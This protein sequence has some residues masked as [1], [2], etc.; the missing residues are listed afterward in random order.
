MFGS[1]TFRVGSNLKFFWVDTQTYPIGAFNLDIYCYETGKL[2]RTLASLDTNSSTSPQEWDVDSTFLTSTSDCPMNQYQ[3]AFDWHYSDPVTL[4]PTV[5]TAKCK[6]LLLIPPTPNPSQPSPSDPLA[7][8]DPTSGD[9]YISDRTKNIII[10]V[11]CAVGVLI[12]AG[13]VGFYFIRYKN[14]RAEEELANQKLR[15]PLHVEGPDNTT[16]GDTG[17]GIQYSAMTG[18]TTSVP[19]EKMELEQIGPYSP[20]T[21]S[22]SGSHLPRTEPAPSLSRHSVQQ[23]RPSGSFTIERPPSLLTS[24]FTPPEDDRERVLRMKREEEERQVFEQQLHHQQQ[25]QLQQQQHQQQQQQQNF[26]NYP[27]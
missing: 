11:G 2:I 17:E 21:A 26:G 9:I 13:V 20:T 24:S 4:A 6:V 15:E 3:G 22:I 10:G 12:I 7:T 23:N 16:S 1:D 8:D 27:F 5:G 19:G 14:R 25:L 18:V